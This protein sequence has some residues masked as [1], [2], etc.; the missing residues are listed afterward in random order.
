[1]KVVNE[2]QTH[3]CYFIRSWAIQWQT[4]CAISFFTIFAHLSLSVVC[5]TDTKRE[6]LKKNKKTCSDSKFWHT[7][8]FY[9]TINIAA[10]D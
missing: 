2:N 5:L 7:F 9:M 1:M 4:L 10:C 3:C 8:R 6:K